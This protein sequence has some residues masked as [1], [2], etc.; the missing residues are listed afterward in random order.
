MRHQDLST[1]S[2]TLEAAGRGSDPIWLLL[3]RL[4]PFSRPWP[5]FV[6]V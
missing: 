6:L 1:P 5:L 3:A 2:L 4:R